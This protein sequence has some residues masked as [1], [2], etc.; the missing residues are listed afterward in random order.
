MALLTWYQETREDR[1]KQHID[2]LIHGLWDIA[3]KKDRYCYY[4]QPAGGPKENLSELLYES[5]GW[6][7]DKEPI[8]TG[9][10]CAC[11]PVIRPIVQYLEMG[12]QNEVAL[13]LCEGMSNYIVYRAND[14][15][16][17]GSF[18]GHFH[19]RVATAA[20]ILK[21]GLYVSRMDLVEWAKKVYQYARSIGTRFGWFPEVVGH[22][23]CETCGITDM[24]DL[25][26]M[27]AEAGWEE[28]WDHAEIYG[29]NQLFQSQFANMEWVEKTPKW[30]Q[31]EIV[32]FF[33]NRLQD[34]HK[35]TRDNVAEILRGGF[36]GGS[37]PNDI[38]DARRGHWMMGCCNAHGVHGLYLLWHHA[39][40]K[41]KRGVFI[42]LLFT[43][44]APWVD[45]HS[46]LPFEGKVTVKIHKAPTVFIRVP[47][48]VPRK[49]VNVD[50]AGKAWMWV[51]MYVRISDLKPNDRVTVSYP[52][53][54]EEE[55]VSVLR[56]TYQI[57]WRGNTVI[58]IDPPGKIG[59]LYGDEA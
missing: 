38:V 30:D 33:D 7:T 10:M 21:Y 17:D 26:I 14:F 41:R 15:E 46:Y 58:S 19:S 47:R 27:L 1:I 6:Q 23:A 36:S 29:G 39:V 51:G 35:Y 18:Q 48:S 4:P 25:A 44:A 43:R 11:G 9:A 13:R 20:A 45:V 57:R 54:E 32:R 59:P 22:D 49:D 42:N 34:K 12:H 8:G 55:T 5:G 2:H 24:I 31:A 53:M 3:I 52:L 50:C 56:D 40:Q 37:A 28:H 16:S